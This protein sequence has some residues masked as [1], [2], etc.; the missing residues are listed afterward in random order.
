MFYLF[1]RFIKECRNETSP[2]LASSVLQSIVDL[3]IIQVDLP[4]LED[5]SQDL[6]TEA[7]KN[8][9]IF[10]S[11]LYLFETAGVLCSLLSRSSDQQATVL[12]SIVKPLMDELS[13]NLQ[14]FTSGNREVLTILRIHHLIMALGNIAKGFPD[15]PN[16]VPEGYNR[17]PL[18]V[19]T[20]VAQ[21]L[22]VCLEN[23]NV[24]KPIR[25]AVRASQ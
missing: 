17:P 15:F 4:Q 10:D 12:M 18:E 11:Q 2:E 22:L 21:A 1:H 9:G 25:E 24:L 19:F 14:T 6:L 5:P 3:L 23:L 13:A 20:Q 16:P 7:L 8:Q